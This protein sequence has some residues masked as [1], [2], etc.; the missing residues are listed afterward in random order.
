V[1]RIAWHDAGITEWK[2][3]STVSGNASTCIPDK[4]ITTYLPIHLSTV[5]VSEHFEHS[6]KLRSDLRIS[7][8]RRYLRNARAKSRALRSRRVSHVKLALCKYGR[9]QNTAVSCA[10]GCP[11]VEV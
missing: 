9:V 8:A 1:K 3:K 10:P 2:C 11:S 4:P 6:G 5:V 7:R